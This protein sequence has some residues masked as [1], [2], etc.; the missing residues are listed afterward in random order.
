MNRAF[1]DTAF[2]VALLNRD[3]LARVTAAD[4]LR[5]LKC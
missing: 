5:C 4:F 3:D 1:A 2:H